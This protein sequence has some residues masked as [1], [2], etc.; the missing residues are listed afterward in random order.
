MPMCRGLLPTSQPPLPE[1]EMVVW[2]TGG[3]P[4]LLRRWDISDERWAIFFEYLMQR[5][6]GFGKS[7][8]ATYWY[9]ASNETAMNVSCPSCF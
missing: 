8:A 3:L 7:L 1:K 5:G 9:T 2:A 4:S 6:L